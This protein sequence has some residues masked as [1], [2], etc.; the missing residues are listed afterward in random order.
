MKTTIAAVFAGTC[1]AVSIPT[2]AQTPGSATV[3]QSPAPQF[4]GLPTIKAGTSVWVTTK[5]GRICQGK[6]LTVSQ[7]AIDL[8]CA[9]GQRTIAV[10]DIRTIEGK[11]SVANGILTGAVV[12][13][14]LGL[15]QGAVQ[16]HGSTDE[17]LPY[18]AIYAAL[19]AP[20]GAG[21][22]YL[23]D[24]GSEGRRVVYQATTP[25]LTLTL[26]PVIVRRGA[27]VGGVIRW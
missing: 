1:L 9:D 10:P 26:A 12:G 23:I 11:D 18:G 16:D 21:L 13:A 4:T 6:V 24:M 2:L 27:G 25:T 7:V 5:D 3:R 8:R 20:I 17:W 22:G 14:G 19:Y 15:L